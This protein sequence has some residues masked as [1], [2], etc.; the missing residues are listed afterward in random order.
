MNKYP[1]NKELKTIEKWTLE[2]GYIELMEYIKELWWMPDWGWKEEDVYAEYKP[3]KVLHRQ[4]KLST[5]GW[6]GNEEIIT[7]MQNNTFFWVMCW[8]QSQRGGY[9]VFDVSILE[10][11]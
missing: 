9:H 1:T 7:A 4:Y 11:E 2:Q 6:S 5:G 10:G 3:T 8:E